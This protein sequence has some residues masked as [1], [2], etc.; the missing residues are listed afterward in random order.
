[1]DQLQFDLIDMSQILLDINLIFSVVEKQHCVCFVSFVL[2][3]CHIH[4]QC[5][6][7]R[8]M[9]KYL[10]NEN[11]IFFSYYNGVFSFDVLLLK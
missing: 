10:V 3:T 4:L 9:E 11:L 2:P 5:H 8:E 7:S 1:M 6:L